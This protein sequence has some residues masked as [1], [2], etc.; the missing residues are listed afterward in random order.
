M[1]V[2]LIYKDK[3]FMMR[4][5]IIIVLFYFLSLNIYAKD[6]NEIN[7]IA[8]GYGD[9]SEHMEVYKLS[10][11]KDLN[12]YFFDN[13]YKYLPKYYETSLGYW[14]GESGGNIKSLSFTP[15]FRYNFGQYYESIP[16]IEAGV[17]AAYISKTKL[18]GQN[19]GTHFQFENVIGIGF[20]FSDFDLSFRYIH[21]SNAGFDSNNAGVD[22]SMISISYKF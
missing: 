7:E 12:N 2:Y 6:K 17:G 13:R 9:S 3:E 11:K 4:L 5:C 21:Y 22:F 1:R 19:F 20:K 8:F 10:I 16:Y 14:K 15:M 18:Q